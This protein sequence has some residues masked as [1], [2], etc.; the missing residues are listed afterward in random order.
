MSCRETSRQFRSIN[1]WK[2]QERIMRF[3]PG[4]ID[5][6][7]RVV[8]PGTQ[9][10]SGRRSL[11]RDAVLFAGALAVSSLP[12]M[13]VAFADQVDQDLAQRSAQI[14]WPGTPD[15]AHADVFSHNEINIDASCSVVWAHLVDASRWPSWYPNSHNV[16]F[17]GG[18]SRLGPHTHF[19]WDT[20]GVQI[21]STV[22]EYVPGTRLGWFGYG[23][24]VAAYHTWL[25]VPDA[26][27]CH[28]VTEEATKGP[29]AIAS[30]QSNPAGLHDGH[31][32]W[33]TRLKKLSEG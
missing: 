20:F 31:E 12:L 21:R 14:H 3:A 4:F 33:I 29:G 1:V 18:A 6:F 7:R 25:L 27:S 24:K 22:A 28:V 15:P 8:T 26:Q 30:R 23:P 11:P 2:L 13:Q 9:R 16:R 10:A 32:L 19:T 17:A 5:R